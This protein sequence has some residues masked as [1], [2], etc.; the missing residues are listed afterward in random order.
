VAILLC[1]AIY[2]CFTLS[3]FSSLVVVDVVVYSA[4]LLLEFAALIALRITHPTM[5]RPV[6]V[7]GGWFGVVL[8]T[9]LPTAVVALAVYSTYV[10]EGPGAIWLSAAA[11]LTGPIAYPLLTKFVKKDTP[12]V[13]V[14]IEFE[15]EA[16]PC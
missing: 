9:L 1:A 3:A 12:S 4:A 16:P 8:V 2:S 10:E 5:K 11:L 15:A 13:D 7:P 6:R 14:P